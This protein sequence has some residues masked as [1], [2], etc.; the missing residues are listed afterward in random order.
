MRYTNFE[1]ACW[2]I[3]GVSIWTAHGNPEQIGHGN[4]LIFQWSGGLVPLEFNGP[5]GTLVNRGAGTYT[6]YLT[7]T[8]MAEMCCEQKNEFCLDRYSRWGNEYCRL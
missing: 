6:V 7:R 5:T 4:I 8:V 3:T 2:E 1:G